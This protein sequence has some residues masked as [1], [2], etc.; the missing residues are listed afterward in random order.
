MKAELL[1]RSKFMVSREFGTADIPREP[2]VTI[3]NVTKPS[4]E[5]EMTKGWWLLTFAESWAKPLKIN[6]TH[7]QALILLFGNETDAW[8]GK[9]IGLHAVVGTFFGRRQ[10]AVRIKGSPD[11]KEPR[12]F[13]VR[14]FG[15]GND[16]Y[17]L[18]PMAAPGAARTSTPPAPFV[19]DG[20]VHCKQSPSNGM[21]IAQLTHLEL[22]AVGA[23]LDEQI[24]KAKPGATWLPNAQTHRAEIA[25]EEQRRADIERQMQAGAPPTAPAEP[26]EDAPF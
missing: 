15:G 12:S 2:L 14:K 3:E 25:A 4:E 26:G 22:A 16:V 8:K 24:A 19:P 7:Q 17:N 10:T 18:V 1:V 5:E 11:L 9:R 13:S 20:L 23:L 6:T 21:Q